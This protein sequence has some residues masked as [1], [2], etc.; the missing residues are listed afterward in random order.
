M[1]IRSMWSGTLKLGMIDIPVT[2]GKSWSEEREKGLQDLCAAHE[3]PVDRSERCS[4]SSKCSLDAGKVKGV[5]VEDGYRVLKPNEFEQIEAETKDDTLRILDVQ[6]AWDVPLEFSVGTYY[7]RFND[8]V[9]GFS[10][11]AFAHLQATLVKG[12]DALV[13]KWCSSSRQRLAV[14]TGESDGRLLLRALPYVNELREAGG[15]ELR[16]MQE[17]IDENVVK[18]MGELLDTMRQP[19]FKHS[20]YSDDG[21][22][23]RAEAVDRVLKGE[24]GEE[25]QEQKQEGGVPDIMA[26]LQASM[27]EAKLHLGDGE[28]E[29]Q[30]S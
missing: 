25:K 21:L 1:S 18:Q 20:D 4:S 19:E 26:A 2:V 3:V 15:Q 27:K 8:K 28:K 30:K 12:D 13:V 16:H 22:R 11:A 17:A 23:L 10:P 29:G 7:I 5:E 24:K 14:I 6:K 9:K